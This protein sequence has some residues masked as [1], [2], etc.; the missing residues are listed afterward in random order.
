VTEDLHV[1]WERLT[2][3]QLLLDEAVR[4]LAFGPRP[5]HERLERARRPLDTIAREDLESEAELALY[6]RIRLGLAQIRPQRRHPLSDGAAS[7]TA[8]VFALEA[9]ASHIVDLYEVTTSRMLRAA[10][11]R[12]RARRPRA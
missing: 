1:A 4:C 5:L 7:R 11:A 8:P 9:T 6:A 3:R 2:A 12:T 10:R